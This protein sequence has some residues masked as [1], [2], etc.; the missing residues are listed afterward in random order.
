MVASIGEMNRE[1]I[2][3]AAAIGLEFDCGCDGIFNAELAIVAEAPGEREVA[4]K[5]PLVGGSGKLLWDTL[6][7]Y[8]ITRRGTY[9]TNVV[10]RRL[11]SEGDGKDSVAKNERDHWESLLAW[12]LSQLPNLKYI[13]VL[14]DAGL[15]ALL[16]EHGVTKWRGSVLPITIRHGTQSRNV[17]AIITVN[18]AAVLRDPKNEII[19]RFDIG[20]LDKV[21]RGVFEPHHIEAQI[22]PSP[23]EALDF[24]ERMIDE[25]LPVAFDIE[26]IANETACVGL[27][28]SPVRGMCINF[29]DRETNRFTTKE[30]AG[31]RRNLQ[32]LLRDS[33]T[34]LVAQ[35]GSFDSYWLWYKDRIRVDRI[36]FDTLLAHHTLYPSLPHSLAFLTA[37]YT[38]HPYYKDEGKDWREGGDVDQF[39]Q[40]NVKDCCITLTAQQRLLRE[41]EEQ[42]LD[43]FFFDHVMRLQPHLVHMTVGGVLLDVSL[44]G[45][46]AAELTEEVAKLKSK[47]WDAVHEATGDY[48]YSPNPGSPKQL[49][50]LFF[51]RLKLVGRGTTT[52]K[53][54]RKR[55][56]D[57]P[58][59]P[60]AA[61]EV[62]ISLDRWSTEAK[63]LSTYAEMVID[64]DHRARCEYKQAG[65]MN[66][67][68]RLSSTKVMWGSGMNLQNQP[69][70]A[71]PM[72]IADE[73][74]EFSYFDMAQ[75]EA[76]FVAMFANI[77]KWKEQFERARIDGSYD[78]HRALASDM[79]KIPYD[80]VPKEDRLE[81]GTVT[82]RFISKRCRHGLN[83]RMMA[84]RLAET[85]GLPLHEAQ[86][87]WH[88]YHQTNPEIKQWWDSLIDE[89]RR[90]KVLYNAFGRRWILLERFDESALE[91]IVAFKPQSTAGDHVAS[92]IY[93]AHE[94][95]EWPAY[96]I[97][98]ERRLAARVVLNIHD[99]LITL[100]RPEDG[101]TVRAILKKHAEQPIEINGESIIV[102]A[103]FKVSFPDDTGMHRWSNLKKVKV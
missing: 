67:P 59:T 39:W 88:V 100:N 17:S 58:K 60:A 77:P 79:F 83:Y 99:A 66:A 70:R 4:L 41:L 68:G 26:C 30:E 81:D 75:I 89:V 7:T 61:K 85:T 35:N 36:W 34:K 65:V 102:P 73:G 103:D 98:G 29:R 44:K 97:G 57:H 62:I 51:K 12:E 32:R 55:M 42:K 14:G 22:N 48:E 11:L 80:E 2:T 53:Q 76:R 49:G 16:G 50:E 25:K 9:I 94:D 63:F 86:H 37:Q 10:K 15:Q 96:T 23:R 19:F 3:R 45:K 92:V 54:N 27:A 93:K 20:K 33:S 74:Y 24:I 13:L 5:Q 72:F 56:L 31:I 64:D 52:D 38:N 28:N 18:P 43:R 95:R 87:A 101:P 46:I 78:A 47:F 84:D 1:L 90:N 91:S 69:Q 71:Y 6:R 82:L 21:L 8:N 40:Y